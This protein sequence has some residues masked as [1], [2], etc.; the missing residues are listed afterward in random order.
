[1]ENGASERAL[2]HTHI[3]LCASRWQ[4]QMAQFPYLKS[5]ER[6]LVV[7]WLSLHFYLVARA[8][9]PL[10]FY[11]FC[12]SVCVCVCLRERKLPDSQARTSRVCVCWFACATRSLAC[13]CHTTAKMFQLERTRAPAFSTAYVLISHWRSF[14]EQLWLVAPP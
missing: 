6:K 11:F 10:L 13:H 7:C 14:C 5:R 4:K 1:M 3:Q 12:L 9:S 2:T 8:H